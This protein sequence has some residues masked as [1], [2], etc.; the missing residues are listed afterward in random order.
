[1]A[2]KMSN[3]VK[4]MTEIANKMLASEHLQNNKEA[5]ASVCGLVDCVLLNKHMYHGFNYYEKK[6]GNLVL[7][8]KE[9]TLIQF[10]IR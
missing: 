9:T 4:Y 3:D 7:A 1:M 5:R 10:Y 8:G 6:D 2:R